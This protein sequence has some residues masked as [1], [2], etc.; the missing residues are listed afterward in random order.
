M[1]RTKKPIALLLTLALALMLAMPAVA[2]INWDDFRI[3]KQPKNLTI[4]YGDS[5]TLS[6]EISLPAGVVDVEYQWSRVSDGR[7]IEGATSPKLRLG[8]DDPYY[9]KDSRLGGDYVEFRCRIYAYVKDSKGNIALSRSLSSN[10]VEVATKRTTLGKVLDVTIAPF[11]YAFS[12][13]LA[14]APVSVPLFPL[15]YLFWLVLAYVSGFRALF[16]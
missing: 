3:T 7:N 13:V 16:S 5:F 4:K 1:K 11:A 12:G 9:P 10:T 8:P 6:V 2:A 14:T 15:A